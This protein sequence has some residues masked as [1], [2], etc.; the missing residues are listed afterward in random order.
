MSFLY[1]ECSLR[2]LKERSDLNGFCC[3]DKDLD[4]FSPMIVL[5]TQSSCWARLISTQ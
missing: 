3:G 2:E 1:D 4:E 5:H